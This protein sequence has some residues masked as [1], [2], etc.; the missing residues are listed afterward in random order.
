MIIKQSKS[1]IS[2]PL[3]KLFNSCMATGYFPE[4]LKTGKITPIFKKGNK[5][6]ME[7][8]RPVSTLPVFGKI[9]EKVIYSRLHNFLVSKGIL[10]DSQFGFRKGHSTAHAIH[11]SVDIIKRAHKLKQHV[12]GIF[13]DFSK[14]FDTLNHDILLKKLDHSGI[15]GTSNKLI[16]SY[17]TG[18]KQYTNFSGYDSDCQ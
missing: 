8:Y 3:S 15:R 9:F 18:R 6:H 16:K 2:E 14:A 17:L 10:T 5:E 11:H 7:N 12:I 4:K 13:I 1:I